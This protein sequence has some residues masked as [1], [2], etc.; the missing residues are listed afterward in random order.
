MSGALPKAV[1]EAAD[2]SAT[3]QLILHE[4]S[5]RDLGP[6]DQ[7]L[8]CFLEDSRV[9]RN[10]IEASGPE[11]VRRSRE[12]GGRNVRARNRLAPVMGTLGGKSASAA[13]S[14]IIDIPF[15][16]RCCR[17]TRVSCSAP[18]GEPAPGICPVSPQPTSPCPAV[19]RDRSRSPEGYRPM[20]RLLA[21]CLEQDGFRVGDDLGGEDQPERVAALTLDIYRWAGLATVQEVAKHSEPTLTSRTQSPSRCLAPGSPT[22]PVQC[23]KTTVF[24]RGGYK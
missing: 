24:F 19:C 21:H 4:R 14:G 8:N 18:N 2:V 16:F 5:G 6:C 10:W 11:F 9:R 23:A 3:K 22:S 12:I 13:L 17:T 1:V 20:R 7:M 15:S